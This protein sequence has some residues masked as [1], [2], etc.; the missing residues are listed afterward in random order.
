MVVSKYLVASIQIIGV[1]VGLLGFLCLEHKRFGEK[2]SSLARLVI[3]GV[4]WATASV[5]LYYLMRSISA[6]SASSTT[7]VPPDRYVVALAAVAGFVAG[8][9][10]ARP[11]HSQRLLHSPRLRLYLLALALIVGS[12][13]VTDGG[14]AVSAILLGVGS[15][16]ALVVILWLISLVPRIPEDKLN[17]IGIAA[18]V[19]G[20]LLAS[21]LSPLITFVSW[22]VQ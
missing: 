5:L 2:G 4:V 22:T 7:N 11:A 14:S 15:A 8:V 1:V 9:F 20:F 12:S 21:F 6:P 10:L 17:P 19:V 18:F 16:V 3:G 13:Q